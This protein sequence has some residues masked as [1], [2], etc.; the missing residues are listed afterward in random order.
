MKPK[1]LIAALNDVDYDMI[2][3]AEK[4]KKLH[5]SIWM[6]WGTAAAC[7]AVIMVAGTAVLPMLDGISVPI[8]TPETAETDTQPEKPVV[9]ES[10]TE[11]KDTAERDTE[12]EN[13]TPGLPEME[14]LF[15]GRYKDVT[16]IAPE[17]MMVWPWEYK[18]VEEKYSSMLFRDTEY[19]GRQR[20][21]GEA[22]IGE[23][24]GECTAQGYDDVHGGVFRDTF[25]VYEIK[26]IQPHRLAAVRMEEHYYVFISEE[27][28]PP[29]VWGDVMAE[30]ALP[31]ALELG[32][33][34]LCG[35]MGKN[36]TYHRLTDD[37]AIWDILSAC[38]DAEYVNPMGWGFTFVRENSM[39][40][41]VSSEML[42]IYKV[43]F[44]I[45][46]DGYLWTNIAHGEYL[47]NIGKDAA[48]QI[49]EYAKANAVDASFEPYYTTVTGTL[50]EIGEDYFL[51]D[52]SVLCK[53]ESEGVVF[54]IIAD[55][56]KIKRYLE[57]SG[58]GLAVGDMVQVTYTGTVDPA[59]ENRVTEAIAVNRC[60]IQGD[61]VLIPE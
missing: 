39:S 8:D 17:L 19:I 55:N 9:Q 35:D 38:A 46:K 29:A 54:K 32:Y 26:G 60:F 1:D 14:D 41:T 4:Q 5:K 2:E 58:C 20:E 18:T 51:V 43:V 36:V 3:E 52:D 57:Y 6:K 42:G 49:I 27:Y 37:T 7:F 56:P 24:L 47:Y 13:N 61:T 48:L 30:Y 53:E 10:D 44:Q 31:E 21:I 23:L 50:T 40:F 25:P 34:S 59:N 28:N 33:F 12:S 22:Y 15:T 45:H 11:G 16:V